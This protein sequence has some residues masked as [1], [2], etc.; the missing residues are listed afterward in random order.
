MRI[1]EYIQR[2]K[3]WIFSGIGIAILGAIWAVV[4]HWLARK[5]PK[6][7]HEPSTVVQ[8][9]TEKS[10]QE[11]PSLTVERIIKEIHSAPPYQKEAVANSFKGIYVAWK[12]AIWDVQNRLLGEPGSNDVEVQLHTGE[13]LHQILFTASLNEYPQLKI[14]RRG[15]QIGVSGT[16]ET[17]SGPGMYVRLDVDEI[18]FG[19]S[20]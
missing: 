11:S 6:S 10:T 15:D 12:G 13:S 14:L 3:E 8:H 20:A 9:A 16:I 18:S 19:N 2:N 5:R 1:L 7:V 17:C 4:R